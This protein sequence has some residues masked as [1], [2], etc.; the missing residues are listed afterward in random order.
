MT[1][2]TYRRMVLLAC[3]SLILPALWGCGR[4]SQEVDTNEP[5]TAIAD[6]PEPGSSAQPGAQADA[7]GSAAPASEE[8]EAES[9]DEPETGEPSPEP[10]KAEPPPEKPPPKPEPRQLVA[11]EPPAPPPAPTVPEVPAGIED[12]EPEGTTVVGKIKLVSSVPD[13][14]TVTY[15]DCVTFIKYQVES[16][17]S[18]EYDGDELIAVFWGMRNSRLQPAAKFSAGQR[19]RL[20]IQP[21]SERPDLQRVMQADDTN[22]YS[23]TP[24]WVVSYSGK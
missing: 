14:S 23:L 5:P 21:L 12:E 6:L 4:K 13:P 19:H 20:T 17:E 2:S 18:G 9:A 1:A 10:N 24:Y 11:E 16:V 15:K 8:R 22:D 7:P 3:I